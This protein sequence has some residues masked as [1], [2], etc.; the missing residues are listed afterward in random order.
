[1]LRTC[2]SS[3][4]PAN[5]QAAKYGARLACMDRE[6]KEMVVGSAAIVLF[7]IVLIVWPPFGLFIEQYFFSYVRMAWDLLRSIF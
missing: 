3:K 7:G 1:M 6:I 4:S 5:R 2:N